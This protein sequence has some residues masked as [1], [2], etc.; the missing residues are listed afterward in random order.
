MQAVGISAL[1]FLV[2]QA[3]AD[4]GHLALVGRQARE[5]SL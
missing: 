5:A 4:Y 3:A 2:I 1:H